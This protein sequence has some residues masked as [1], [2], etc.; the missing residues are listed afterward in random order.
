MLC[1]GWGPG[2]AFKAAPSRSPGLYLQNRPP[3]QPLPFLELP[4]GAIHPEGWLRQELLDMDAGMTGHLDSLY[5]LVLGNT[6]GWLGGNGDVWERGPYWLDGLVPLAYIL[7]DRWLIAKTRPWIEWTLDHQ[8]ADGYFGPVPGKVK[9]APEPGVQRDNAQD[10]WPKMVMLKVLR[11]YYEA[12]ADQRVI[13]LMTRYFHYQLR[14]LPVTSLGHWSWW[15]AQRGGDNLLTVYWLY[16]I[17]GDTSLLSLAEIIHRQTF[18]WTATFLDPEAFS[19][20]FAY[21]G[22][23]LA[24]GLKEPLVYYQQHPDP[25]YLEAGTGA[26]DHIRRFLGQPEGMYGADEMTHGNDPTQG[27]EFCSAVEM[28]F[29][30][31]QMMQITGSVKYMDQL[32]R[33]TFNA[34]PTQA[35][36]DFSGR[37]YYQQANQVMITRHL[38]NFVTSYDGTALCYGLLTGY[39]CCTVNM[40]QG[41]PKYVQHLWFATADHGAAALVYGSSEVDLKVADGTGVRFREQTDYPFGDTIHFTYHGRAGLAFPLKMRIPQWCDTGLV[42]VN[43]I[44]VFRRPGNQ[45]VSLDR[46]WRDGDRVDLVLPMHITL[47]RWYQDGEA[48]ERGPLVFGL[49]IGERWKKIPSTDHYGSYREVY[50]TSPWNYGLVDLPESK[51]Q[52]DF[53]V[54]LG[55]KVS[56]HP[57][58]IRNAPLE[59]RAMAR[60]IPQ[61]SLYNEMAGPLPAYPSG[62]GKEPVEQ[63]TLVPYG[64]T[65]LR[66]SE[67]PVVP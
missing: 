10:W 43:G 1:F 61:W 62:L 40:S 45:L 56:L 52:E 22:V 15:G 35:M 32:E 47:T 25:R 19:G 18:D 20:N 55:K 13:R 8:Q 34:L 29:S 50:P 14:Q 48:V 26:L 46:S 49:K 64:C 54:I 51:W 27:S 11:Q 53:P 59:I 44:L 33:I 31:E 65:V 23:N 36:Q 60:R 57:W 9:P 17:T 24:Q 39:P 38:R 66:I 67:F 30:L 3:L 7:G 21:H 41:W 12:T 58:S 37:Q 5:A 63:V 28:M 4:I 2:P 42:F 6:N 16:N